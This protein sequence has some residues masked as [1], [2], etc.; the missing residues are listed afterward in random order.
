MLQ[1]LEKPTL[2]HRFKLMT[3]AEAIQRLIQQVQ[4]H[5]FHHVYRNQRTGYDGLGWAGALGVYSLNSENAP[6][7]AGHFEWLQNR[8]V[9]IA[10]ADLDDLQRGS[11]I[12]NEILEWGGMRLRIHTP[13]DVDLLNRVIAKATDWGWNNPA[14]MNSSWTKVAS[15]FGYP[16]GNTIWDSRVSTAVCFRLASLFSEAGDNAAHARQQFPGLGFIPGRSARVSR[17]M[18][19]IQEYWRSSYQQWSGHISGSLL[20]REIA[21]ALIAQHIPCPQFGPAD[22]PQHPGNG[23]WTPWKV[24]MAFF[25]DDIIE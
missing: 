4:E 17:R 19:L 25:A 24:N 18:A 1:D 14:P 11:D 7:T 5:H 23:N 6:N 10:N 15:I 9:Q 8:L 20:M 12:A 22:D 13:A 16:Q 3:R 2:L 21:E